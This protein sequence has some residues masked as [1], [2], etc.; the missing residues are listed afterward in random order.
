[1]TWPCVCR[2]TEPYQPEDAASGQLGAL[3]PQPE[4]PGQ[5]GLLELGARWQA[6]TA[7]AGSGAQAVL[8]LE[9]VQLGELQVLPFSSPMCSTLP[10]ALGYGMQCR[11]VQRRA[12]PI[13]QREP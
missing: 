4:A 5:A 2:A 13:T 3:G 7:H 10:D 9:A 12:Q 1:M 8:S 6:L 11:H